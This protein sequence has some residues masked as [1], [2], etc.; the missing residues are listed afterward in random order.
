MKRKE[1][2]QEGSVTKV[3]ENKELLEET[4]SNAAERPRNTD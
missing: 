3:K 4:I 2:K 1:E